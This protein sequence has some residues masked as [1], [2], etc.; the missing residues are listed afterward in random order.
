[1][2]PDVPRPRRAH[3]RDGRPAQPARHRPPREPDQAAAIRPCSRSRDILEFVKK[4]SGENVDVDEFLTSLSES[5]VEVVEREAVDEGAAPP[6]STTWS[7]GSPIVNLVNVALLT[8]VRD[9]AS[10]IH[11]EPSPAARG[12]ATASTAC[13]AT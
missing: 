12:S 9:G 6:T 10:D 11:I 2:H 7:T 13:C 8:A 4:Y 5:D 1:V 3:G